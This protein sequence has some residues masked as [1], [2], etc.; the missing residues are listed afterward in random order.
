VTTTRL[1]AKPTRKLF[2]RCAKP[3]DSLFFVCSNGGH[4]QEVGPVYAPQPPSIREHREQ[5]SLFGPSFVVPRTKPPGALGGAL[6]V[7]LICVPW[8]LIGWL[9]WMAA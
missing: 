5:L 7:A 4:V 2:I 8:L 1:R 3:S 6:A 9:I